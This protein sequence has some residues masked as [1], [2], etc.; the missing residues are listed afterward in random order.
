[1][2]PMSY[3]VTLALYCASTCWHQR[4]AIK[5]HIQKLNN[6]QKDYQQLIAP[7]NL[8]YS[9]YRYNRLYQ[10]QQTNLVLFTLGAGI[11][12]EVPHGYVGDSLIYQK[13]H[14]HFLAWE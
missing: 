8:E 13:K 7:A 1:M 5:N 14:W 12:I 9:L 2:L 6:V 3:Q 10:L 11:G 4:T